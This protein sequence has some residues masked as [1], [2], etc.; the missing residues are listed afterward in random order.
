MNQQVMCQCHA[1]ITATAVRA[2]IT[3]SMGNSSSGAHVGRLLLLC[4]AD[5]E[6][7]KYSDSEVQRPDWSSVYRVGK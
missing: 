2:R 1:V 7:A 5:T 4:E 3:G 6:L